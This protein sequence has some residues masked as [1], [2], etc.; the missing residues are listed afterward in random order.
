M[1]HNYT[2][3]IFFFLFLLS[4]SITSCDNNNSTTNTNNNT[5]DSTQTEVTDNDLEENSHTKEIKLIDDEISKINNQLSSYSKNKKELKDSSCEVFQYAN[6]DNVVLKITSSCQKSASEKET[7]EFYLIVLSGKDTK[8]ICSKYIKETFNEADNS[9]TEK[10]SR[11]A[12]SIGSMIEGD[13]H[14][15]MVLDETGTELKEEAA[16]FNQMSEQVYIASM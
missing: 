5:V 4:L 6:E 12:Y 14:Y 13:E 10:T 11:S 15:A 7:W 1:I 2:K 3:H 8:I 9:L 16:S